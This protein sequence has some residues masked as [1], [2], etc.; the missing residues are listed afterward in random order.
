MKG[1]TL[2]HDDGTTTYIDSVEVQNMIYRTWD[3]FDS[4]TVKP[5]MRWVHHN[6]SWTS[7]V[8]DANQPSRVI[9]E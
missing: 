8:Q 9:T 3:Q 1:I 5:R 2:H 7:D 6:V 4:V